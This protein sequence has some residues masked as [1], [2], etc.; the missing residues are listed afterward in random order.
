MHRGCRYRGAMAAQTCPACS[1]GQVFQ[2]ARR[3]DVSVLCCSDCKL[4][5]SAS[6]GQTAA[7]LPIET[8]DGFYRGILATFRQQ[9]RIARKMLPARLR[10]YAQLLGRPVTSILEVG[11]ATGA[12]ASA[13]D[14][15]GIRYRGVEVESE[16]AEFAQQQTGLDIVNANF[17]ELPDG[18]E[19]DVVYASQVLEH[20]TDP[21]AF[22][23]RAMEFAP[24]GLI[25]VDVP[26]HDS[27]VASVRKIVS[28]TEFGFIQP[29]HH[30]IAYNEAAL[31]A[32]YRRC[33][34]DPVVLGAFRNDHP[35]WG[36]LTEASAA[37]RLLY[38]ASDI[39]NKGSL[40][41]CVGLARRDH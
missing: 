29:P 20:V 9:Q 39:F 5:F 7:A 23:R 32:L 28:K 35:I 24:R 25:H 4:N 3:G 16:L 6:V 30:M 27:L 15:L 12:C 18:A 2:R 14:E 34:I 10:A 41:V 40:L 33:G 19:F 17:F 22:I 31:G 36:Q 26:N 38:S 1:S 37:T 11:C 21:T 8:R 13:Y